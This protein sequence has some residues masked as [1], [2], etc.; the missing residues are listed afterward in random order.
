MSTRRPVFLP[1]AR[2][3]GGRPGGDAQRCELRPWFVRLLGGAAPSAAA[4]DEDSGALQ[5]PQAFRHD[6]C[7]I[8]ANTL[9]FQPEAGSLETPFP[10]DQ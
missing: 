7:V 3:G 1:T 8:A 4:G 6:R 10:L 2:A 9:A 5:L